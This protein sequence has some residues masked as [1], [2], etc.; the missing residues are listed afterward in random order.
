VI[1]EGLVKRSI[2]NVTTGIIMYRLGSDGKD[3]DRG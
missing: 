2:K 3:V 1:K